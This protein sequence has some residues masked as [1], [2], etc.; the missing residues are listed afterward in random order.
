MPD[1]LRSPLRTGRRAPEA[2]RRL[3]WRG[4]E[5]SPRRSGSKAWRRNRKACRSIYDRVER[6]GSEDPAALRRAV[7]VIH[8]LGQFDFGDSRGISKKLVPQGKVGGC[9]VGLGQLIRADIHRR[10]ALDAM[11][12]I[13]TDPGY[14]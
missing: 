8:R 3:R 1:A 11:E 10:D 5:L 13:I 2:G 4:G 12:C 6:N 14:L 9:S 7:A